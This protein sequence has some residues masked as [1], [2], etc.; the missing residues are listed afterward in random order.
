MGKE[1]SFENGLKPVALYGF[2]VPMAVLVAATW[3]VKFFSR[4]LWC[5][6]PQPLVAT[7]LALVSV[8]GRFCVVIG[9]IYLWLRGGPWGKSLL[10]PEVI[11]CSGIAWLGL[12]AEWVF[13]RILQDE[14][15]PTSNPAPSSREMD[16]ATVNSTEEDRVTEPHKQ[17][18]LTRD[19]GEWFKRRFPNGHKL[20]VWI[21]FPV[22]YVTISSLAENGDPRAIPE[23][24]LRLA[25]IAA[26]ILQTFWMPSDKLH[27]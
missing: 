26:A 15:T 22:G 25:V 14:F 17:S 16:D 8:T 23:A 9:V 5:A 21:L 3:G 11:A 18:I 6:I 20:V 12:G 2:A 24:I 10:L 7:L 27:R 1:H 19:F 13:I 4:L